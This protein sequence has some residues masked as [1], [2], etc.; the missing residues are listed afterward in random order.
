MGNGLF[1]RS[2]MPDKCPRVLHIS[3]NSFLSLQNIFRYVLS[4]YKHQ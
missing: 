4:V 2:V 3:A 1:M